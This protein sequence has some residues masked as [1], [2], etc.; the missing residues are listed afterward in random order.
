[1]FGLVRLPANRER[2]S[3]GVLQPWEFLPTS[4]I[5]VGSACYPAVVGTLAGHFGI[6]EGV[7][8]VKESLG[9]GFLVV[10]GGLVRADARR[11]RC[12]GQG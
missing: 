9:V 2:E 5:E 4:T 7:G 11:R 3:R 6:P 12:R 1:M 8:G 10:V